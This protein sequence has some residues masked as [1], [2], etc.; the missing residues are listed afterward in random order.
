LRILSF[1]YYSV[2]KVQSPFDRWTM[3]WIFQSRASVTLQYCRFIETIRPGTHRRV[4]K[5]RPFK[6]AVLFRT[7]CLRAV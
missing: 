7:L 5:I 6:P 3:R 4:G 2:I 1:S